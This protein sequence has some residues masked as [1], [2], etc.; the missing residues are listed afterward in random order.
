MCV[1]S[2]ILHLVVSAFSGV[3]KYRRVVVA[4]GLFNDCL[5]VSSYSPSAPLKCIGLL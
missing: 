4:V 3:S 2:S 5:T 1:R